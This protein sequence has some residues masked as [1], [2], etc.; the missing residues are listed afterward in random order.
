VTEVACGLANVELLKFWEQER[1]PVEQAVT[2][3]AF[4]LAN[5]ELLMFQVS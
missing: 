2:E 1:L 4:G 5:V 3:V